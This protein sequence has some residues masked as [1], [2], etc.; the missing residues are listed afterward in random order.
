MWAN[1][2]SAVANVNWAINVYDS[3][4]NYLGY[5]SNYSANG[6]ISFTWGLQITEGGQPLNDPTFRLDYFVSDAATGKSLTAAGKPAASKWMIGE[7]QWNVSGMVVACTPV[8]NNGTHTQDV[9]NMVEN[10]VLNIC[11]GLFPG[12]FLPA[13]ANV[14]FANVW[15]WGANGNADTLLDVMPTGSYMYFFGHGTT[16]SFGIPNPVNPVDHIT[17]SDLV[18]TLFNFPASRIPTNSHPYKFVFLDG[19][20]TG[21]GPLCEAFGIPSGQYSTNFF[22]NSGVRN[23]AYIGYTKEV[24]FNPD[25]WAFRA[26]MLATFW[27][28]WF[29]A[30]HSIHYMVTNAQAYLPAP[31]DSSAIIYGATNMF[32]GN[33]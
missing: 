32:I 11:D 28:N 3:E 16:Y 5:F 21:G 33:Y 19:C 26:N 7:G 6:S 17:Y 15:T 12:G 1:A 2:Q 30:G 20:L 10:G 23:R 25:Q 13:A 29:V 18:A 31:M 8:D 24:S 27:S 22:N 4:T 14:P 9:Q